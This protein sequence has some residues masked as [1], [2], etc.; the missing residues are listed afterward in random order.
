MK[1]TIIQCAIGLSML[2]ALSGTVC[3]VNGTPPDPSTPPELCDGVSRTLVLAS[4]VERSYLL[5][6]P[7]RIDSASAV[8]LVLVFHGGFGRGSRICDTTNFNDVAD[9]EGFIVAYPNGLDRYWNDGR[10]SDT[11]HRP[12]YEAAFVRQLVAAISNEYNIDP[13][14]IYATGISNG[15]N[16]SH[17]LGN[18][19]S[20]LLA[21]IAPVAGSIGEGLDANFAPEHPVSVLQIH[22]TADRGILYMG[23]PI[24]GGLFKG[25]M[26]S[27]PATIAHWVKA[28]GCS[29]AVAVEQ[30]PD[31]DPTDGVT[32][33]RKTY[34][35]GRGHSE[36]VL[37]R[38]DQGG[39]NWPGMD[40][41]RTGPLTGRICRDFDATEVIWAFFATHP[42][43]NASY[44][45]TRP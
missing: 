43:A 12:P 2:L 18:E 39:H 44:P 19:L 34:T 28:N 33:V 32:A 22:G 38:I 24:A 41:S 30:M 15:G 6:V 20:D 13:A 25:W 5:Y 27:V 3:E 14:H 35:G 9:R 36:V 23:G 31:L 26:L 17:L 37:I 11:Y 1:R 8:P 16:L 4:G 7:S 10:S 40:E 45:T 42:K 21:A 29:D